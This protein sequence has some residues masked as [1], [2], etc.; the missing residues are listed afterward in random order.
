M[1]TG[2]VAIHAASGMKQ[3]EYLWAAS[4]LQ[5]IG[6]QC[7]L[8]A[9]LPRRAII[10]AVDVVDIITE[11]DSPWF[12]GQCGLVLE[13]PRPVEPIPVVGELGYFEWAES[14]TLDPPKPWMAKYDV[15]PDSGLFGELELSFKQ[16]PE[17]PYGRKK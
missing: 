13:N 11:S 12:G 8:P 10:G 16:P 4:K 5:Q 14:G 17:K 1:T 9:D 15:G 6:V 3:E 7:P 2:P